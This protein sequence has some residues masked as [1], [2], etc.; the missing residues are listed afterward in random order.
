MERI[1]K[2]NC[3]DYDIRGAFLFFNVLLLAPFL[4]SSL[5]FVIT[6]STALNTFVAAGYCALVCEAQ[7]LRLVRFYRAFSYNW[8][9]HSVLSPLT[10]CLI[11]SERTQFSMWLCVSFKLTVLSLFEK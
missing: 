7:L 3:F 4:I 6:P 8:L 5:A 2:Q 9:C 10:A 11:I 1:M